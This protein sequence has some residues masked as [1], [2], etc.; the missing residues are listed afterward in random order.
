MSDTNSDTNSRRAVVARQTAET[1][2]EAEL[3]LDGGGESEINTGL[4]F[5]DHM[6]AQTARHGGMFLRLRAAGDLQIDGHHTVEDCGIV[7][8]RAL[9]EAL[10]EK[11]GIARFG[12]AFAPL[13]ESLSRAVVDLSGRPSLVYQAA[14]ARAEIGG[15]DSDLPREFFQALAN[16]AKLTL[17][18]DL[19]RGVNAHHQA[20]SMFKAFGLALKMAA[21]KTGGGLPSTKGVL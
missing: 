9:A 2:I 14:L 13:D 1:T 7:L 15:M 21:T 12:W 5:F 6:L 19:L 18:L 3:I 11:C 16:H 10:G 20:E 4:P 8:G 17:H